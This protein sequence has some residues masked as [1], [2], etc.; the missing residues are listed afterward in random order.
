MQVAVAMSLE[1]V[2][3]RTLTLLHLPAPQ[4]AVTDMLLPED[5][6]ERRVFGCDDGLSAR[7]SVNEGVSIMKFPINHFPGTEAGTS[8]NSL[9]RAINRGMW[10]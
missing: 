9:S 4:N 1:D 10:Q 3:A 5:A 7:V 8:K 2:N 6:I